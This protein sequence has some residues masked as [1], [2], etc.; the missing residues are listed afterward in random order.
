MSHI[1]IVGAG[2]SGAF[3]AAAAVKNPDVSVDV[4]DR[5]P[6]PFGLIRYGVA[7]DH[8]KIKSVTRV[9]SKTFGAERVRFFGNVEYGRDIP[10][11]A[12]HEA[13][14]AVLF[15]T[16]ST[17]SR[18]L[19]IAG[20]DLIGNYSAADIVPWYNGHPLRGSEMRI[21][22]PGEKSTVAIVGAGNVS[23]DIARILLKG[24]AGL[25]D[26]DVPESVLAALDSH[27]SVDE[28]HIIV[29]R[30]AADVR[31]TLPELQEF[32]RMSEE[33]LDVTIYDADLRSEPT[34]ADLADPTAQ[35][36]WDLFSRWATRKPTGADRRLIFHFGVT[37]SRIDGVNRVSELTLTQS[38]HELAPTRTIR[39]DAVITSI[40]YAGE[41]IPGLEFDHERSVIPNELGRAGNRTYVAGWIKRGPT[42]VVGANKACAGETMRVLLEDLSAADQDVDRSDARKR[43]LAD[44][45]TKCSPVDW[46]GWQRIDDAEVVLGTEFGCNRKKITDHRRLVEIATAVSA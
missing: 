10:V 11:G 15:A 19:G 36:R 22:E 38:G 5:L 26:T 31:F 27:A 9:L 44:L 20:E 34:A 33:D 1:A 28:V 4:F 14:D 13:Y 40:G 29:R 17:G 45:R 35:Q 32:D 2:P 37:P 18:A 42:G 24:R 43:L 12:L 16:G 6:T 23:L 25:S 46:E 3:A 30:G 8:V 41:P 21:S 39:V 7:P